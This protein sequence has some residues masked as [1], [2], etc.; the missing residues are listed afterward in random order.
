L[1]RTV[2]FVAVVVIILIAGYFFG[3]YYYATSK[4]ESDGISNKLK[5]DI[6]VWKSGTARQ[7]GQMVDY[8]ID[9]IGVIDKSKGEIIDL[10]GLSDDSVRISDEK[11]RLQ[12]YYRVDKGDAFALDM[13]LF[14]DSTNQV[15][16][17]LFDD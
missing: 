1:R 16:E 2:I 13:I 8:L 7:R 11:Y 6:E 10:L 12:L 4:F 3:S 17:F 15:K 9:S 5:F 14:F